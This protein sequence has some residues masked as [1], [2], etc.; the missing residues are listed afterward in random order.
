MKFA[1]AFKNS[2]K[3]LGKSAK[4]ATKAIALEFKTYR[5]KKAIDFVQSNGLKVV[6]DTPKPTTTKKGE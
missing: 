5:V 1:D 2:C 4:E 3:I 6:K